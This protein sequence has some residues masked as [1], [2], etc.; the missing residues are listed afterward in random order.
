MSSTHVRNVF[1]YRGIHPRLDATAFVAPTASIVGDVTV[2]AESSIWYGA[3]LRGDVMPIRIGAR[4]SIQDNTVVHATGGWCDAVVGDDCTVGHS[5]I[6]H[7]CKVGSRVLVGMGSILLDEAEIGDE[8]MI[9][10]GSLVTARARIPSGVLVH[11]RPAKVVRDL[12]PD[13][14]ERILEASALYRRYGREHAESL[15]G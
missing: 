3:V 5:V 1:P 6:L 2:G 11:G 13:E 9:G 15:G 12:R 8:V 4:T 10:A 14:L 7:G